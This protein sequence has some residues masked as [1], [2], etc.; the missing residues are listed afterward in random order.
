MKKTSLFFALMLMMLALLPARAGDDFSRAI[1]YYLIGDPDL[2]RKNLDAH[3]SRVRQNTVKLGFT[4]LFQGEKWEA[5]KKFRDYL[6]GSHRSLESLVGISLANTDVKSSLA[7]DNLN[8]IVRL[9]PGYAPAYLCLGQEYLARGNY[10]AAEDYFQKSLRYAGLPEFKLLLAGLLLQSGREQEALDLVG[11]LAEAA[12]KNFHFSSLAARAALALRDLPAAARFL[13]QAQA[14]RPDSREAQLLRGQLLLAAGDPRKAKALLARLKFPAYN[15]EY[16]LTLAQALVQLKDRDAEK[17]L[18]EVFSQERWNPA[19]NKLLGLFHLKDKGANVQNWL[20][21][22]VL[23]G[24]PAAELKREFPAKYHVAAPPSLPFFAVR[25]LQWLGRDRLAVAGAVKSGEK[26]RLTVLDAAS[27][28]PIHSFE[29]E[30][31]VQE[32]FASPRLDK[33]IFSTSASENEKIYLYTLFAAGGGYRLKPVVG[34]A[35][36]MA[37]AQVAFDDSGATAYVT[38]AG[39]ADLAFSSPFS[40]VS[41]LGR[42]KPIYPDHPVAVFSY[43]FASDRWGPLRGREALRRAPLP[44]VRRYLAV[45]DTAGANAEVAKLLEKGSRLDITSAEE[46]RI[47]FAPGDREF[48]LVLSDLKNAFQA[49]AYDGGKLARFD[50]TMFLGR[51]QYSELDVVAFMPQ[52]GEIVVVTRDKQRSLYQF[53]YRSRLYKKL[54][55]G[56]LGAALSP[57]RRSLYLLI[58]RNQALYYSETALEV[59]QLSPFLRTRVSARRDLDAILDC[60][61]R[62]TVYVT[63]YTGEMLKMDGEGGFSSRQVSLAGALHQVSPDKKKAAAFI[64]GRLFVLAWQE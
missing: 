4:L 45:A 32:I 42:R 34:Y 57:D 43:S 28:K 37:R 62:D 51:D 36:D 47:L 2:A 27:L 61:D 3:F 54:A 11:P 35:L 30:G 10:P 13:D 60:S 8:K 59:I 24:L 9:D 53:N 56:V 18:Y 6:E 21:R 1:A 41:G 58:E 15:L 33:I 39:L 17:Y 38:D 50:E 14:A 29:Y 19:V 46:M 31:T 55:S 63:T 64:N 44:L 40:V 20:Q 49:W 7:I 52:Q 23:S 16:S 25:R 12:G 22:A 5:S 26:E 48:L